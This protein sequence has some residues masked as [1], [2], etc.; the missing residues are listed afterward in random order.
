VQKAYNLVELRQKLEEKMVLH[1]MTKGSARDEHEEE[2]PSFHSTPER[3][4]RSEAS[5][6]EHAESEQDNEPALLVP[7]KVK[8]EQTSIAISNEDFAFRPG[9]R[10]DTP[11]LRIK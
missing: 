8:T 4:Q 3:E 11:P 5:D 7:E 6:D 2:W 1:G 9:G 10:P